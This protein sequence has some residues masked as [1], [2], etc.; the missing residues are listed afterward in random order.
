MTRFS[1]LAGGY[2]IVTENYTPSGESNTN[3]KSLLQLKNV[4]KNMPT[5][6]QCMDGNLNERDIQ[7][8]NENAPI[9]VFNVIGIRQSV[10][11]LYG[12]I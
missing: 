1:N 2:Q 9:L 8:S 4:T 7:T 10:L 5:K 3:Y 11:I 12:G 6:F